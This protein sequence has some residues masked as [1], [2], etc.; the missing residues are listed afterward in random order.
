VSNKNFLRRS[1]VIKEKKDTE[2]EE[3]EEEDEFLLVQTNPD[4]GII[5]P[6]NHY[7]LI[8]DFVGMSFIIYQAVVVPYKLCFDS[9]QKGFLAAF[10]IIQDVFF[11]LDILVNFNTGYVH[12]GILVL[13]RK[14][15]SWNYMKNWF[16]IDLLSSFPYALLISPSE[17]FNLSGEISSSNIT[18]VTNILRILKL[19]KFVRLLRLL[20][21]A[22]L[23]FLIKLVEESFTSKTMSL[24]IEFVKLILVLILVSHWLACVWYLM[25][26]NTDYSWLDR[27]NVKNDSFYNM[28]ITSLYFIIITMLT[29]GFGDI[30]PINSNERIFVIFLQIASGIIFSFVLGRVAVVINSLNDTQDDDAIKLIHMKKFLKKK[31]INDNLK[32]KIIRY[33][34]LTFKSIS[35]KQNLEFLDLLNDKLRDEVTMSLNKKLLSNFKILSDKTEFIQILIREFKEELVYPKETIYKE[36]DVTNKVY[37]LLSGKLITFIKEIDVVVKEN[38]VWNAFGHVEFLGGF[39]RRFTV[40]GLT[41]CKI[42]TFDYAAF[43]KAVEILELKNFD[44]FFTFKD[45]MLDIQT[46]IR[47]SNFTGLEIYCDFCGNADHLADE[48]QCLTSPQFIYNNKFRNKNFKTDQDLILLQEKIFDFFHERKE[49]LEEK[50]LINN[51]Y[52][53]FDNNDNSMM[54]V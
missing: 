44:Y 48:C 1:T 46:K 20:R 36:L 13:N 40:E 8:W 9:T 42:A 54:D 25:G 22:K 43:K 7:K 24:V 27:F 38:K 15:I 16:F 50:L 10:E 37:F 26:Q 33:L 31:N 32:E 12:D 2:E 39:D 45:Y 53:L 23:K 29:V 49:L 14:E 51:S 3:Y 35:N 11:L 21:I 19:S 5:S 4:W 52:E 34:D 47:M 30:Y 17:Y 18:E 6:N 28:Y 41:F